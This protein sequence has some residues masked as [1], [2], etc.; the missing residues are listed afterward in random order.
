MNA[1]LGISAMLFA[2]TLAACAVNPRAGVRD[3]EMRQTSGEPALV[4]ARPEGARWFYPGGPYGAF[5]YAVDF[6]QAGTA[7]GVHIAINDDIAAQVRIGEA[8]SAVLERIGPPFRKIRFNN[9][10]QTA[11]DYRYRDTWGYLVEFS[12]MI[13]DKALVA[14]KFTRRLDPMDRNDQ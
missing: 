6:D 11:W 9:L 8:G 10:Q 13:D 4:I 14:G 5:S 12:V 1:I 7:T 3:I 2:A